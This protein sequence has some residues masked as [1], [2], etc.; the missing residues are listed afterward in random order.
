MWPLLAAASMSSLLNDPGKC[1]SV[2]FSMS[3]CPR[4]A[5]V[6]VSKH[7]KGSVWSHLM[8]S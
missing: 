3:K 7:M 6:V 8:C 5:A 2:H 1:S 4:L